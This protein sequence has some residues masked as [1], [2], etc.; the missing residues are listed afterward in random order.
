MTIASEP[1]AE[2]WLA[3]SRGPAEEVA[4]RSG[5]PPRGAP[6]VA[7]EKW[8]ALLAGTPGGPSPGM[9]LDARAVLDRQIPAGIR[10]PGT[11]AMMATVA[12]GML[13]APPAM[14]RTV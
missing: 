5:W 3:P 1:L 2:K 10:Q 8:L 13:R 7:L 9:G 12:T 4:R 11:L 6:G 14:Q